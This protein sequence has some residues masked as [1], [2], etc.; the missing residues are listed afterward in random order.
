MESNVINC[1]ECGKVN[2]H[3]EIGTHWI[4]EDCKVDGPPKEEESDKDH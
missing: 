2:K 3:G 4:C 1:N